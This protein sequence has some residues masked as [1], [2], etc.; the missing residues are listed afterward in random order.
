MTLSKRR[1][2]AIVRKE[3]R[4]Y[5]R[6]TNVIVTMAIFP[7]IFLIQPLVLVL[8]LPQETALSLSNRHLLL[9]MLAIPAL[10]PA[11]LSA[12]AVVGERQ[13]D[14][15]EPVLTTPISGEELLLGKAL[16][17][18][19][20]TM[21]VSYTVYAFFL[22]GVWLFAR[23]TVASGLL[24]GPD[25]ITQLLLTPLLATWSIWAGLWISTRSSDVRVAQQFSLLASLPSV[26]VTSL[27]AF[28]VIPLTPQVAVSLTVTL[29]LLDA[30]GWRLTSTAFDR[31]RLLAGQR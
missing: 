26:A 23:P 17:C 9:Y 16:A 13:Q 27:I 2:H 7:L 11:T 21:V 5:R 28:D 15:L 25:L 1:V 24:R 6:N 4:E 3:T 12:Y 22:T 29:L 20:P 10:V 14:T 30:T 18:L 8:I 31:E 19:L